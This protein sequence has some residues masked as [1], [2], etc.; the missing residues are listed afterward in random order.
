MIKVMQSFLFGFTFLTN[1]F[2][3][4]NGTAEDDKQ[5]KVSDPRIKL[6]PINPPATPLSLSANRHG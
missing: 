5:Q 2:I 4:L 6:H 1:L 3:S